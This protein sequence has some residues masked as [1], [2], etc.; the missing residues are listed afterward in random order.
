M[1][2]NL[3]SFIILALLVVNLVLTSI[4][5]FSVTST[6]KKVSD[7]IGNIAV[8][9]NLELT[10][11][12]GEEVLNAVALEDTEVYV[13][14]ESMMPLAIEKVEGEDGEK[15][16]QGYLVCNI[17]LSINTKHKDYKTYG[18]GETMAAKEELIKDTI[19][20]IVSKHTTAEL[21]AD[22]GLEDLKAEIL[23]AVQDLFQSDFIYKISISEVKYG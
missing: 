21:Q 16:K 3:L 7:L 2:K 14:T 12:G 15:P 17:S 19:S 5:M 9:L 23:T 13:I 11:P 8:A 10:E 6:N 1:K 18:S 22:A 4:M 20:G